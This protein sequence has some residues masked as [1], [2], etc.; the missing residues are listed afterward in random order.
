MNFRRQIRPIRIHRLNERH[1]FR[2]G[3]ALDLLLAPECLLPR[4]YELVPDQSIERVSRR[5]RAVD[6]TL[7]MLTYS[8]EQF[9]SHAGVERV[10][11]VT[12]HV[13]GPRAHVRR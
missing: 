6:L 9:A 2:T 11:V 1:A 10:R 4:R 13:H 5:E 7:L 3:P 8:D 12:H